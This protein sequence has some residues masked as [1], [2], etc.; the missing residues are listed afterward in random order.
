MRIY[1][2]M[3]EVTPIPAQT[4]GLPWYKA[5]WN[6]LTVPTFWELTDDYLYRLKDGTWVL[7]RKGFT[8]DGASSPRF[9]WPLI[10]PDGIMFLQ[11]LIHDDGY[12]HDRLERI[13]APKDLLSRLETAWWVSM[14]VKGCNIDMREIEEISTDVEY[15]EMIC[16]ST[17]LYKPGAGQKFWD[18]MFKDEGNEIN[19][20][21]PINYSAWLALRVFGW[22]AWGRCRNEDTIH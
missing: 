16:F 7:F 1:P 18:D 10:S 21:K 19:G 9:T 5:A 20:M 11:G 13:V 8:F 12:R 3:P 4:K 22:V 14:P 15:I 17:E 2:Q 6:F